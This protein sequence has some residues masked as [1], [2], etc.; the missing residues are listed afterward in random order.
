MNTHTTSKNKTNK[1]SNVVSILSPYC[2]LYC[3]LA[4]IVHTSNS[5]RFSWNFISAI[6]PAELTGVIF[7]T[8][9]IVWNCVW[10]SFFSDTVPLLIILEA[11]T[12]Y[13][14]ST[15]YILLYNMYR[16]A[17]RHLHPT[18]YDNRYHKIIGEWWS[19][20]APREQQ[21]YL[22]Y[23]YEY[24]SINSGRSLCRTTSCTSGTSHPSR[25]SKASSSVPSVYTCYITAVYPIDLRYR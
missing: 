3:P 1:N 16:Q 13:Y 25:W 7:T 11:H 8:I 14:S 10:G 12:Y 6:Q 24:S 22:W 23:Y 21:K 9:L 2:S 4:C 20:L 19:Q 5:A 15:H 17:A 18:Y